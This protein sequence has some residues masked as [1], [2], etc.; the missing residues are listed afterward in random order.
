M[1][2]AL[3]MRI[4]ILK[5]SLKIGGNERSAANMS[6]LLS[7]NNDVYV[8]LFDAENITYTY[9]GE[10]YDLALPPKETMIGKIYNSFLRSTSLKK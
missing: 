3:Y 1:G 7:D 6:K 8:V 10:I 2:K 4:C 5:E 9:G